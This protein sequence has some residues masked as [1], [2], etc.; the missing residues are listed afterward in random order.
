VI[1]NNLP[2]GWEVAYSSSGHYFINVI[3]GTTCWQL[4]PDVLERIRVTKLSK[5][6][7]C[8]PDQG[9]YGSLRLWC[10]FYMYHNCASGSGGC[11][12]FVKENQNLMNRLKTFQDVVFPHFPKPYWCAVGATNPHNGRASS[13]LDLS[14]LAFNLFGETAQYPE[15]LSLVFLKAVKQALARNA[16]FTGITTVISARKRPLRPCADWVRS[17]IL[18]CEN[19]DLCRS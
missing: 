11:H 1:T 4:P 8:L 7:R 17:S 18:S 5:Y 2:P 16:F 10:H 12:F 9:F 6:P 19:G 3:E 14:L 13:V 15:W